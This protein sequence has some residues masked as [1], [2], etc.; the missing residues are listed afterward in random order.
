MFGA[1]LIFALLFYDHSDTHDAFGEPRLLV[2]DIVPTVLSSV[3]LTR[4]CPVGGIDESQSHRS[5]YRRLETST[6]GAFPTL[7]VPR[8]RCNRRGY[9]AVMGAVVRDGPTSGNK[10]NAL[11][12]PLTT[13]VANSCT[14]KRL[15]YRARC[16]II[17]AALA[18]FSF[19]GAAGDVTL[20]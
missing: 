16:A 17:D 10:H 2:A 19:R 11:G 13:S 12:G 1:S 9:R 5:A 4:Q 14:S 7:L 6:L 18:A 3:A 15:Q 8:R 20:K